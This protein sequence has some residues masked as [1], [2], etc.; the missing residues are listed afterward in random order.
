MTIAIQKK[1]LYIYIYRLTTQN[2]HCDTHILLPVQFLIARRSLINRQV[3][4][5]S[6]KKSKL[7]Q[8]LNWSTLLL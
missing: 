3:R 1:P 8:Y 7:F 6:H 4:E 5:P 2:V